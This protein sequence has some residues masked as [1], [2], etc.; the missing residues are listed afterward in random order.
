[1]LYSQSKG[2]GNKSIV[3]IHGN[4]QSHQTWDGV[5]QTG[6]LTDYRLTGVDLPGHGLSLRSTSPA[7]DYTLK[8]LGSNLKQFLNEYLD[9]EFILAGVSLG[10]NVIAEMTL[11]PSNCKGIFLLGPQIIG[12]DITPADIIKPNPNV[13]AIF[14]PSPADEL[15]EGFLDDMVFTLNLSERKK[16]KEAFLKTDTL[17]RQYF[18]G[19]ITMQQWSDEI[20]NLKRSGIPLAIIYGEEER[21]VVT[22]Y[23]EKASLIKW[24]NKTILVPQAGHFA[25]LDQPH[26]VAGLINDFAADCFSS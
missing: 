14:T 11:I 8:G 15:L 16:C 24:R 22:D 9:H 26:L 19:S 5:I 13:A 23:L 21:F 7:Q 3:L 10:C 12:G 18:G 25:H 1:M 2:T 20:E 17:F 4:S 6:L